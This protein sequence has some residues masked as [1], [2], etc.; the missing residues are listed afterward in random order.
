MF[1]K[2]NENNGRDWNIFT[3]SKSGAWKRFFY[4]LKSVVTPRFLYDVIVPQDVL[5]IIN[6]IK[7]PNKSVI[8]GKANVDPAVFRFILACSIFNG[9]LIGLPGTAGWGV[10]AAQAVEVLM[11]IQ[12]AKMV[13]LFDVSI[14]AFQKILKLFTATAIT[15]ISVV[16]FFKKALSI[17]FNVLANIVPYGFTTAAAEIVTTL[18]FGLFLY[19]SFIEIENFD[20]KV[21]NKAISFSMLPRIV[22]NTT[23][24]T[25]QIAKSLFKLI[26]TDAPRL[27]TE[28]KQ[29]VQDTWS[30]VTDVKPRLKGEIFL[31]GC[32]AYL[33]DGK[34]EGLK[35][36]FAELWL[37]AWREALP[38]RLGENSSIEDIKEV[39]SSYDQATL[40]LVINK[41]I[42]PKFFEILETTHE[43]VDGDVWSA[44]LLEGQ[45]H[46]VS[47]AIFYNSATDKF[48]EINYKY[49]ENADYIENHIQL[50]PD[51]PV[52]ATADVAD[53]I[54]SPLVFGG[55]YNYDEIAEISSEN[56]EKVLGLNHSLYIEAAAAGAGAISL[57]Y[58]MLPFSVAYFKGNI[59]RGQFTTALKKFIPTITGRT[60]NRIVLF[61]LLGPIYGSFLLAGFVSTATLGGFENFEEQNEPVKKEE[62]KPA[63]EPST[64]HEEEPTPEPKKTFSRR[65]MITL[66]FLEDIN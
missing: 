63:R 18:F 57:F 50:Y 19:L 24:Y 10:L 23:E 48:I 28:I 54:N 64:K 56:F 60:I 33:L 1:S 55:H 22:G 20:S 7:F 29:N 15:A 37:Q 8:D 11:A 42:N 65:E 47:D 31:V 52:V 34:D 6:E 27:F 46:P 53:K 39:A 59:N 4:K 17:V 30:G 45:N 61:S 41:N 16:Y 5:N 2:N 40:E 9:I 43:N 66:S 58:Y 32:L 51:V 44:E 25:V 14:F 36:P 13:G 26:S 49:S 35:G 21:K 3:L 38:T 12:I 62:V